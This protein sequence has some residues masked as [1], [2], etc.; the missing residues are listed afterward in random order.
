[1]VEA[2]EFLDEALEGKRAEPVLGLLVATGTMVVARDF[3]LTPE[4]LVSVHTLAKVRWPTTFKMGPAF[5]AL[6][7]LFAA[8]FSLW[9]I[10]ISSIRSSAVDL[11]HILFGNV[12]GVSVMDLALTGGLVVIV[13][14]VIFLGLTHLKS[15]KRLE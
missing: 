3:V 11:S 8:A 5:I 14:A 9:V 1:V 10:L 2:H 13:L 7:I 4:E 12:L 15:R 6:G